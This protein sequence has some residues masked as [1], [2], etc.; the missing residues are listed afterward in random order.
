MKKIILILSLILLTACSKGGNNELK[1]V[2]IIVED[3]KND[4]ILFQEVISTH[5]ATL[6]DLIQEVEALNAGLVKGAYGNYI[7]ALCGLN[8][9]DGYYWIYTSD[10]NEICKKMGACPAI[11]EV[12]LEDQDRFHFSYT[13]TFE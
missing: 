11:A 9:K 5:S 12:Y 4:Q 2:E 13:D 1:E 8:Q 3:R 10:N 7:E 6:D